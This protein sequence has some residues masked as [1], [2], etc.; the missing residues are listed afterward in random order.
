MMNKAKS[1]HRKGKVVCRISPSPMAFQ[2]IFKGQIRY[3]LTE[4]FEAIIICSDG[5]E[6]QSVLDSEGC[7]VI[8]IPFSRIISLKTDAITI[9]RLFRIFKE[10]RP[11]IVHTHTSKG[12]LLGMI[13]AFLAG[14]PIRIHSVPG[15]QLM[16]SS[17]VM[18]FILK[19]SERLTYALAH[20][21]WP[22]SK[23]LKNRPQSPNSNPMRLISKA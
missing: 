8:T 22:N 11:D 18:K 15:L 13:A 2:S 3:L 16:E 7:R 10:V 20:N 21:I 19:V 9:C 1:S 4:G 17:G 6:V 23:S 14:V 12:G 5:P